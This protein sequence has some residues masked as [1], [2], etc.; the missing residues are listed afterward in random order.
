MKRSRIAT[1]T[2]TPMSMTVMTVFP[3]QPCLLAKGGLGSKST[4][5]SFPTYLTHRRLRP[6][7]E[8]AGMQISTAQDTW[9]SRHLNV[10]TK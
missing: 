7:K 9:M 6:T 5:P 10:S 1:T 3:T 2:R 8:M 4:H